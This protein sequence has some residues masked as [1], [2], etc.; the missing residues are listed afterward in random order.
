MVW[1]TGDPGYQSLWLLESWVKGTVMLSLSLLRCLRLDLQ[2]WRDWQSWQS[3]SL[4]SE[5]LGLRGL[6]RLG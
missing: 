1:N 6:L 3:V 4:I 5:F 2:F